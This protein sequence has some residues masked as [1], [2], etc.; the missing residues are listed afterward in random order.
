MPLSLLAAALFFLLM[1]IFFYNPIART[2]HIVGVVALFIGLHV[3]IKRFWRAFSSLPLEIEVMTLGSVVVTLL[4]GVKAGILL[5]VL[6]TFLSSHFSRGISIYTPMMAS[7]YVLAAVFALFVSPANIIM[8]GII[9]SLLVNAYFVIIFQLVGYTLLEN[10][11]YSI[12]NIIL[13]T[14]LF[15][16]IAPWLLKMLI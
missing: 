5:A 14:L 3:F 2:L 13:N 8:G 7:G 10:I 16:K 12:S 9:I 15:V 1:L 4:F 11:V 6:G